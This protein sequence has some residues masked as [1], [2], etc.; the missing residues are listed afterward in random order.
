MEKKVKNRPLFLTTDLRFNDSMILKSLDQQIEGQNQDFNAW[1][2]G[3]FDSSMVNLL[4][5]ALPKMELWTYTSSLL[6][7]SL[8]SIMSSIFFFVQLCQVVRLWV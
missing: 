5:V 8:L 6:Y 4:P 1:I 7:L 2:M 3:L